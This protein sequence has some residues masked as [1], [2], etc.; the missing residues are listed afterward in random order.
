MCRQFPKAERYM[1]G[2]LKGQKDLLVTEE[3]VKV[4]WLKRQGGDVR[5]ATLGYS[6]SEGKQDH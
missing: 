1:I 3:T 5:D 4:K 2:T 6:G